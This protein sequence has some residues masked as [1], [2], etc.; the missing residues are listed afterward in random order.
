MFYFS[1]I[2]AFP[3]AMPELHRH[4]S[5]MWLSL[6]S[7]ATYGEMTIWSKNE[8]QSTT[9]SIGVVEE[10]FGLLPVLLVKA[11]VG[12]AEQ[13]LQLHPHGLQVTSDSD[14]LSKVVLRLFNVSFEQVG[15]S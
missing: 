10:V 2:T 13:A 3:D 14:T 11:D 15:D 6:H 12:H 5:A 4:C 7:L 9:Y 1:S 8:C